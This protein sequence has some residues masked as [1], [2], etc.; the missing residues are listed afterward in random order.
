[1]ENIVCMAM[2]AM[3]VCLGVPTRNF[4]PAEVVAFIVAR[5]VQMGVNQYGKV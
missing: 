1:M 3:R 2:D 5:G 4:T